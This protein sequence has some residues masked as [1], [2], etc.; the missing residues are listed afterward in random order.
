[1]YLPEARFFYF[2][3][4]IPS[5]DCAFISPR[6][7]KS[8]TTQ[9]TPTEDNRSDRWYSDVLKKWLTPD[10]RLK[11]HGWRF[12]CRNRDEAFYVQ[13]MSRTRVPILKFF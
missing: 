3:N 7:A 1:M 4:F 12:T 9:N 5:K 6:G 8:N 10:N 11:P 2:L 13:G